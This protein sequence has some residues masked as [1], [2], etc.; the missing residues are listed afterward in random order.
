[1]L[2]LRNNTTYWQ[3]FAIEGVLGFLVTFVYLSGTDPSCEDSSF[4]PRLSYGAATI[5]AHL[6]G[7]RCSVISQHLNSGP[8]GGS[9]GPGQN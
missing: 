6:F 1:M 3:G 9:G 5:G 7:V 4:G 8:S 2:D